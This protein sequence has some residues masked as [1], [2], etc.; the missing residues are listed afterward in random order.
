[1]DESGYKF[2]KICQ[3]CKLKNLS[4]AIP[5]SSHAPKK[6]DS[7]S[8]MSNRKFV[9]LAMAQEFL[10]ASKK[11]RC[12]EY[13]SLT[14]DAW[15]IGYPKKKSSFWRLLTFTANPPRG[16]MELDY[17]TSRTIAKRMR[18]M[19]YETMH[20]LFRSLPWIQKLIQLNL[21]FNMLIE[22]SSN[23]QVWFHWSMFYGS[24]ILIQWGGISPK[25]VS[26]L[27]D[28][29]NKC[30]R[31]G[32][33]I[34]RDI[35]WI[36]GS[37]FFWME[38]PISL[39]KDMDEPL[40]HVKTEAP[41]RSRAV[42]ACLWRYSVVISGFPT[43]LQFLGVGAGVTC[44]T[45]W[46]LRMLFFAICNPL[47]GPILGRKIFEKPKSFRIRRGFVCHGW[48]AEVYG[49]HPTRK[50]LAVRNLRGSDSPAQ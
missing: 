49:D 34:V 24:Y 44:G 14:I 22:S 6:I 45:K 5:R 41:V 16:L 31:S 7:M 3:C 2:Y 17:C 27:I 32:L 21:S 33:V 8:L 47:V 28:L 48:R 50:T 25:G 37:P 18:S 39:E 4:N 35:Q 9:I 29:P 42:C 38:I 40:N 15:T 23:F 36:L 43:Q 13:G 1:M 20:W 30:P 26:N 12:L 19:R 46:I 11:N 10:T